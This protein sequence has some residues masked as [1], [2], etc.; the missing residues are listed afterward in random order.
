VKLLLIGDGP[1]RAAIEQRVGELGLRDHTIFAGS[2]PDVP[3]LLQAMDVF[4]FPSLWEGLPLTVLEAQ[5]AGLPCVI[6]DVISNETDVVPDMIRRVSVQAG[7]AEWVQVVLEAA[8]ARHPDRETALATLESTS[9]N[10]HRSI[11]EL[12]ALYSA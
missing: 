5:A 4:V 8:E 9:F 6:S 2:R 1:D 12:Y 10:I 7:A 11:E 3:D